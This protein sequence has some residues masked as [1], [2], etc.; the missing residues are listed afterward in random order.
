MTTQQNIFERH[1]ESCFITFS[2]ET[3]NNPSSSFTDDTPIHSNV[4]YIWVF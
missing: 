3:Q 4:M 2:M 1:F